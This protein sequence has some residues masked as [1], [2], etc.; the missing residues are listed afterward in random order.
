MNPTHKRIHELRRLLAANP[1]DRVA[2]A[3]LIGALADIRRASQ[4]LELLPRLEPFTVLDVELLRRVVSMLTAGAHLEKGLE[5]AESLIALT[6]DD[7]DLLM[8]LG[9]DLMASKKFVAAAELLGRVI[10]LEPRNSV[11]LRFRSS[12]R[13]QAGE[14]ELAMADAVLCVDLAPENS[15][16]RIHLGGLLLQAKRFNEAQPHLE[17]AIA[18]DPTNAHAHNVLSSVFVSMGLVGRAIDEA[19]AAVKLEPSLVSAQIHL[20]NLLTMHGR[21]RQAIDVLRLSLR[22]DPENL[23]ARRVL[24]GALAAA[25]N[26]S[27]AIDEA[28]ELVRLAPETPEYQM[29]AGGLM[30]SAE[31]MAEGIVLLQK[32]C[33]MAPAIGHGWRTLSGA[34]LELG[35]FDDAEAH[36]LKALECEPD[37]ADYKSHLKNLRRKRDTDIT[38][39]LSIAI[40]DIQSTT[41]YTPPLNV[42]RRLDADRKSHP[43][44]EA[45]RTQ[46]RVVMALV[47]RDI[48]AAYAG[49]RLGYIW[50]LIEPMTHLLTL[51]IVFKILNHS[52]PPIG[53]NL[54]LFYLTGIL[55]F[56]M[57]IH[58]VGH[59]MDSIPGNHNLLQLPLIKPMDLLVSQ[60]LM[61]LWRETTVVIISFF[62]FFC[63]IG[64]KAIP[65]EPVRCVQALFCVWIAATGFGVLSSMVASAF[66]TWEKIWPVI[67]RLMYFA[68]GIFYIP[69]NMPEWVRD[70]L[71]WNPVL[72]GIEW[73]RNGFFRNYSPHWLDTYYVLAFGISC[74]LIG[75]ALERIQHRRMTYE[76]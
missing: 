31:R 36:A 17:K 54:Y 53:D 25:G 43:M 71:I 14:V 10:E 16:F 12:A 74:L 64:I 62:I 40:A 19:A 4:V 6:P 37:N 20:G 21:Y 60:S 58:T 29:H 8:Q 56:L 33:A 15:E 28:L 65:T 76:L 32:A 26:L 11:A 18:I 30:V 50:A 41:Q 68:S 34:E 22:A 51:G 45:F 66:P 63:I 52:T 13:L 24:S 70:Y 73:F 1:D 44:L 46:R 23:T 75:L 67:T 72:Q 38:Q 47:L 42:P 61:S 48:R 59:M 27:E 3:E 55:P 57:F 9:S 35:H 39:A 2:L 5:I 69:Q 49:S 7:T